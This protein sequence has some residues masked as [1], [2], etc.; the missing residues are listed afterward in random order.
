ML[1]GTCHCGTLNWTFDGTPGSATACNCTL[2]RRYGALW[3]YDYEGE[4]IRISGLSAVYTRKDI[5]KPA[6][7]IHFCTSCGCI[8]CWRALEL[9][10]DGRRRIA[11]NLRLTEPA[12]VSHLP[13]DHFDG[14]DTFDDLPRD[15]CCV[16]D[17][18]F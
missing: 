15:G 14:L 9:D 7:E 16:A 4:R 8:T 13:V 17:V 6:L 11:V 5:A 2:C 10:A 18:W 3:I 1:T 12:P